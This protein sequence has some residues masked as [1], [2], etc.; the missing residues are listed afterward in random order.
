[1]LDSPKKWNQVLM[2][3]FKDLRASQ[4]K[5]PYLGLIQENLI[6]NSIYNCLPYI[7]KAYGLCYVLL[8]YLK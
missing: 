1:M 2:L 8:A 7:L 4:Y 3:Q 6:E 5:E